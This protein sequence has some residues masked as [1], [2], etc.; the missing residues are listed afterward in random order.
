ML[1]NVNYSI[2]NNSDSIGL[3]PVVS[4]EW[5]HN[6]FNQ[7]YITVAGSGTKISGLLTS[8]T[9][10][11]VTIG[12]KENFTTKSFEMSGGTGSVEYTVSGLSGVSYK[13]VTY[14]KTNNPMPVMINAGCEGY[15]A[16]PF[17][18]ENLLA[19]A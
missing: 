4:A 10:S 17:P 6:L 8:G 14:V 7:P 11:D 19:G 15:A 13:V 5:N 9:V 2:F 12:A 18:R 3:V 16:C 1:D